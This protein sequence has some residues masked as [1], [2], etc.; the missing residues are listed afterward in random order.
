[1]KKYFTIPSHPS[2][3]SILCTRAIPSPGNAAFFPSP[4]TFTHSLK[5]DSSQLSPLCEAF[6]DLQV[7]F[8]TEPALCCMHFF[9]LQITERPQRAGNPALRRQAWTGQTGSPPSQS[10][11][12]TTIQPEM[13]YNAASEKTFS[14]CCN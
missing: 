10:T 4:A 3:P 12:E 8:C 5:L 6:S 9:I 11:Q 1:M 7:H 14:S 13:C 2:I